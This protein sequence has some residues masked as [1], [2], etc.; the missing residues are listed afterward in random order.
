MVTVSLDNINM[1]FLK[2]INEAVTVMSFPQES[3]RYDIHFI[4]ENRTRY[5][6]L[7]QNSGL[8]LI[9]TAGMFVYPDRKDLWV[10]SCFFCL[11]VFEP[12]N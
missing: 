12:L 11:K 4:L 6:K 9:Y 1:L 3:V 8:I 2:K 5:F 7:G 10:V